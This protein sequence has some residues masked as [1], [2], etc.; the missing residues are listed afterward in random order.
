MVVFLGLTEKTY[1]DGTLI[2]KSEDRSRKSEDGLI[3]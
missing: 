3:Y 1:K 2:L